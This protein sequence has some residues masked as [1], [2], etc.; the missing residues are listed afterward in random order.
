MIMI[1]SCKF[2]FNQAGFSMMSLVNTDIEIYDS[3]F[4]DNVAVSVT[5][6]FAMTNS[7]LTASGVQ[8]FSTSRTFPID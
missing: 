2:T 4:E 1:E 8:I 7:K 6:G 5:N 3:V